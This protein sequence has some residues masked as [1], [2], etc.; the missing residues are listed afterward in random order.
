M[1]CFWKLQVHQTCSLQKCR[2]SQR[3]NVHKCAHNLKRPNHPSTIC[4][5]CELPQLP[6]PTQV[7]EFAHTALDERYGSR[8]KNHP[9]S[10][11]Q[12]STNYD[13]LPT[14]LYLAGHF[15]KLGGFDTSLRSSM[16][17]L[18]MWWLSGIWTYFMTSSKS[19]ASSS[20]S[21]TSTSWPSPASFSSTCANLT[22]S[23]L[24]QQGW[25]QVLRT[26]NLR[27]QIPIQI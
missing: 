11:P 25:Q 27:N 26:G 13:K 23:A 21:S 15:G 10:L 12:T 22:P 8:L 19:S 7:S 3:A 24:V 5:P 14:C 16:G 17:L 2:T 4:V 18:R 20:G 9:N 1:K 6:D